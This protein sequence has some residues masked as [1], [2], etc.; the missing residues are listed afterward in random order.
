MIP[1]GSSLS[2]SLPLPTSSSSKCAKWTAGFFKS[3][4]LPL[5]FLKGKK[6]VV[7]SLGG[8]QQLGF[9]SFGATQSNLPSHP[10]WW[11]LGNLS[12]S[13]PMELPSGRLPLLLII[14]EVHHRSNLSSTLPHNLG[15]NGHGRKWLKLVNALKGKCPSPTQFPYPPSLIGIAPDSAHQA[16]SHCNSVHPRLSTH[17]PS[18]YP[19][20]NSVLTLQDSL[21]R[22]LLHRVRGCDPCTLH[23]DTLLNSTSNFGRSPH[24]WH[25]H[26]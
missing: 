3:G 11:P 1:P 26:P 9:W 12:M 16:L 17:H 19:Y 2:G 23:I 4:W 25:P 22:I 13:S 6:L 7:L 21:A 15:E 10:P 8:H 5:C 14:W 18:L 20:Q 24:L